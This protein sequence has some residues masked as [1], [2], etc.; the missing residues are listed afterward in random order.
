MSRRRPPS[1]VNRCTRTRVPEVAPLDVIQDAKGYVGA[2]H[3]NNIKDGTPGG[4][5]TPA[6]SG[7]TP[8]RP[9]EGQRCRGSCLLP[10]PLPLPLFAVHVL[11]TG[12]A[13]E[14]LSQKFRDIEMV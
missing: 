10:L 3:G 9:G 14:S 6:G 4:G 1:S 2:C 11:E 5:H 12:H 8:A 13:F 7:A